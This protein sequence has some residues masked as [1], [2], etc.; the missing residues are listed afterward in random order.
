MKSLLNDFGKYWLE[1]QGRRR[2]A[3]RYPFREDE[4]V[5][6]AYL[7]RVSW[8]T[9]AYYLNL[10]P[11]QYAVAITPAGR[12]ISIRGGYNA[13]L[14]GRYVLHYVDKQNRVSVIP[15]ISE[16]T[17]DGAQVSLE[18]VVNYQV[19]DPFLALEVQQPVD[20][21][22]VYIQSDLKEFIRTHKYDEI[23]GDSVG[24]AV[25][26]SLVSQYIKDQHSKREQMSRLLKIEEVVVEEKA[27]DP[28][29]NE[30]RGNLQVQQRQKVAE[31]EVFRHTQEL[32][33]KVASQEAEIKKIKAQAD[34]KEQEIRQKMEHQSIQLEKERSD[35]EFRQKKM[36]RAMDA[37]SQAFASA[38]YPRDP[39]E[40]EIIKELL[41]ALGG[42]PN[43]QSQKAKSEDVER[44]D[45]LTDILLN[46][47]E[48]KRS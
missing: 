12:L 17:L 7:M 36:M 4:I 10:H 3:L 46:W 35:L 15:R 9:N 23:V 31:G 16:T 38:P 13:L 44:I 19:I 32:E 37:I 1:R 18:L 39:R 26:T 43:G 47:T 34:A 45:S 30:I 2:S 5:S 28:K 22:F 40:V 20:T 33:R 24:H 11:S 14:P 8:W 21:F 6:P 25:D 48:R 27:G 29:L 41:G 42:S